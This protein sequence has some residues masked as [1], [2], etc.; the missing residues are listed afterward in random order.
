MELYSRVDMVFPQTVH[1]PGPG[2][3]YVIL[4]GIAAYLEKYECTTP[5]FEYLN[6]CELYHTGRP[7][8][9][10]IQLFNRVYANVIGSL[11]GRG[12]YGARVLSREN[13]L[14]LELL[15]NHKYDTLYYP[16]PPL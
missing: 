4:S 16:C 7:E 10:S 5:E 1:I 14:I 12:V 3:M 13:C 8:F 9:Y 11:E 6:T 15:C 2:D